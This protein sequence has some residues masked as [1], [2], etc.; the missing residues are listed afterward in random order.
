MLD[1]RAPCAAAAGVKKVTDRVSVIDAGTNVV[2][3]SGGDGLLIVDT[4]APK[5]SDKL[6]AALK[7]IAA[8]AKVDTVFNTHYHNCAGNLAIK[9]ATGCKIHGPAADAQEDPHAPGDRREGPDRE[10]HRPRR[11]LDAGP[12]DLVTHAPDVVP[13]HD[14]Q[15]QARDDD[16]DGEH[17]AGEG[18]LEASMVKAYVCK[19]AEWVTREAVQI[20][21]GMGYM[22]EMGIETTYRDARIVRIYEGTS[23]IQRNIIARGLGL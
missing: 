16:R 14:D 18:T 21:G 23:E 22:R 19:A 4:G 1:D 8:N 12:G 5:S 2:V 10:E 9:R 6:T 3:L 7:G 17:A 15:R 20:H 13:R 11:P